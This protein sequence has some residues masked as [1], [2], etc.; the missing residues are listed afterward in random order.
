MI[1]GLVVSKNDA[2]YRDYWHNGNCCSGY[3]FRNG[4]TTEH[5]LKAFKFGVDGRHPMSDWDSK[6]FLEYSPTQVL[7]VPEQLVWWEDDKE[8]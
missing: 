1:N 5:C 7:V 8:V 6:T 2:L 4:S 3:S